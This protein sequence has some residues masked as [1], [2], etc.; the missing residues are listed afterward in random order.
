MMRL[1][2]KNE[3]PRGGY[4]HPKHL[5]AYGADKSERYCVAPSHSLY[6]AKYLRD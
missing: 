6:D 1:A 2:P 4:M 3:Q 5:L